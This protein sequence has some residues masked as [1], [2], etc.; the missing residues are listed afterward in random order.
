MGTKRIHGGSYLERRRFNDPP[1][2][3]EVTIRI[4]ADSRRVSVQDLFGGGA[5]AQSFHGRN[6]PRSATRH[7]GPV[8][9][10]RD[11]VKTVEYKN[12]KAAKQ[13]WA[14]LYLSV[15]PL[16]FG[17]TTRSSGQR[18]VPVMIDLAYSLVIEATQEPDYFGFYSPEFG[19]LF[20]Y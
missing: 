10:D 7:A 20:R 5:N 16:V 8:A 15:A 1:G 13:V 19:R 3:F 12:H 14:R 11:P 17:W 18:L 9:V 6:A 2:D 4:T